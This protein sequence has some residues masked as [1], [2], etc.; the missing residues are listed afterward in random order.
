M[1]VLDTSVVLA[2]MDR[3]D[4][5][6]ERVREWLQMQ[7]QELVTTPLLVAELDHLVF[8]RGGAGGVQALRDDF[9]GEAYQVEWWPT[10]IHETTAIAKR[11]E[12]MKL[13]LSDASLVA[14]AAHLQT[15]CIATLDERHFR[16]VKPLSS[17]DAFTLL[18]ADAG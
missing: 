10:A 4:V 14:L 15:T 11:Y 16:A 13:G 3:R 18:P 12:S 9:D 17:S 1:I 6:H 8:R 7:D 5:N 2:F